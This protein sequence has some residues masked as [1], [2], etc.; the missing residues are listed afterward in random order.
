MEKNP[1]IQAITPKPGQYAALQTLG[2]DSFRFVIASK[3]GDSWR[4]IETRSLDKGSLR[5]V[6][7]LCAQH[8]VA[9]LVRILPVSLCISKIVELPIGDLPGMISAANLFA[10]AELPSMV[11]S[12]R[13]AGG[14]IPGT[15]RTGMRYVLL[16]G[17][18]TR[19]DDGLDI[20]PINAAITETW[21]SALASLAMLRGYAAHAAGSTHS[22]HGDTS[23]YVDPSRSAVGI[24][25]FGPEKPF[26]RVC[27]E[28][29]IADPAQCPAAVHEAITETAALVDAE[30]DT[31]AGTRL[32][33]D[34]RRRSL[35]AAKFYGARDD[36]AWFDDYG[37][38]LGAILA[39]ADPSTRSL[40]TLLE[41]APKIEEPALISAA[42][43]IASGQR[44]WWIAAAAM[45]S[46]IAIPWAIAAARDS[47]LASRA[48]DLDKIRVAATEIETKAALY[49]QL[50]Q[51]RLPLTKLLGDIST[52]TPVGVV[53]TE[54]NLNPEQGLTVQ[55]TAKQQDLVN[56]YQSNLTDTKL[57][58]NVK[59]NRTESTSSG[60]V[61]F[62]V[63][64]AISPEQAHTPIKPID[65]FAAQ[66]LAVRMYG[67]EGAKLIA[68]GHTATAAAAA[69]GDSRAT[70]R[71][72]RRNGDTREEPTDRRPSAST[73]VLPP[74]VTDEEIKKMD[75]PT[76]TREWIARKVY[77][78]KNPNLDSSIKQ[79]LL[80]EETRIKAHAATAPAAA[81]KAGGAK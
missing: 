59:I 7:G 81:P 62:N 1:K 56:K 73:D 29:E 10:E 48:A 5:T 55:G 69:A 14:L 41:H 47:M 38:C 23:A 12:H 45:V 54:M 11:P 24:L 80:D 4:I 70:R 77:V 52:A 18:V 76:A 64:A 68:A 8:G 50:S 39:N 51:L 30:V 33:I 27:I 20:T 36:V 43:W 74:V 21:C 61:G 63:S 3:E 34:A 49:S 28:D 58:R 79:R 2:D 16:T 46:I 53:I 42:R 26:I 44:P 25:A 71:G 31:F 6:H 60:E 32:K 15:A 35:I 40:T 17:W 78:Q 13:R 22:A 19:P 66:P 72:D 67:E 75:K 9:T 65:D 57:F 37:I